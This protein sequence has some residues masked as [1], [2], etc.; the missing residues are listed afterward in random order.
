MATCSSILAWRTPWTG[1][2]GRLHGVRKSRIRL[3]R[4]SMHACNGYDCG[5]N[6]GPSMVVISWQGHCVGVPGGCPLLGSLFGGSP[7]ALHLFSASV[8]R[9]RL[10]LQPR[11]EM[12]GLFSPSSASALHLGPHHPLCTLAQFLCSCLGQQELE[13]PL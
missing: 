9:K 7:I 10:A 2:P 8:W 13:L 5:N 3:K 6:W 4:L 11:T 1:E 12:P